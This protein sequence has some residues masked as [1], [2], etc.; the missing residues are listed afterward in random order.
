MDSTHNPTSLNRTHDTVPVILIVDDDPDCRMLIRDAIESNSEEV[1]IYECTDGHDGLEF[2]HKNGT[3]KDAP[4]PNVVF[5]D[6]EMPRTDGRQM[7]EIL[8]AHPTLADLPVVVLTGVDDD[9]TER[10]IMSIGA[11]SYTCKSRNPDRLIN[12]VMQTAAYWTRI[13]RPSNH[14]RTAA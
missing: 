2:L 12:T 1:H 9:E 14:H 5:L 7:L 13:H 6:L 10:R 11:N 8:R 4:R 3:Y